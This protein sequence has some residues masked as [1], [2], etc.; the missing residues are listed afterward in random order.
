MA[1]NNRINAPK[2]HKAIA[3]VTADI[4]LTHVDYAGPE[5]PRMCTTVHV[6]GNGTDT[7]TIRLE[8]YNGDT[9]DFPSVKGHLYI[10][11]QFKGIKDA[12]TTATNIVVGY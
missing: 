4:D 3:S 1:Q 7:G 9:V 8:N 2:Y 10:V 5:T 11:G 12:G 6:F